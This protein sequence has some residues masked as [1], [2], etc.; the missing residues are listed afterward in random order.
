VCD[1]V[2]TTFISSH[3]YV[4]WINVIQMKII[5]VVLIAIATLGVTV[6]TIIQSVQGFCPGDDFG[7]G[8]SC[9]DSNGDINSGG[10]A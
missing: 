10:H 8:Q 5:A 6:G 2:F 4:K 3:Y 1:S 9:H 7:H